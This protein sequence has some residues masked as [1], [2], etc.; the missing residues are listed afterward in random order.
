MQH[1]RRL[2][3]RVVQLF[4]GLFLYGIGIAFL[5]RG[6]LG[7]AP[8]DVLA[9]GVSL[10]VPL[11]FGAV[12]VVISVLVMLLWIP[13]RQKPGFGTLSNMLLVGPF[14][15]FG[16]WLLPQPEQLWLRIVCV[17][18]GILGIAFATGL[19]IGARFGPGPRDGLM[20]GL[21]RVTGWPIWVVRTLLEVTVVLIGWLLGG[22]FG[23]GTVA[24]ALLVGP[25]CQ[26]FVPMCH[27]ALPGDPPR[28]ASSGASPPGSEDR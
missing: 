14:A 19:Y 8:W 10:H 24:F 23:V 27:I 22:V 3:R 6:N 28:S 18:I 7:A 25:A 4:L 1:S 21:I 13:L 26:L 16:L 15:D 12:T 2:P 17:P 5:V 9:Q 11:S 20:T